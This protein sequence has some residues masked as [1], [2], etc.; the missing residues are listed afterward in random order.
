M[1]HGNFLMF[2]IIPIKSQC[3]SGGGKLGIYYIVSN[4]DCLLEQLWVGKE[5]YFFQHTTV[6]LV[7]PKATLLVSY[8]EKHGINSRNNAV[9]RR[10]GGQ[11]ILPR[12]ICTPP[13]D[14]YH[15]GSP[16]RFEDT[17][18]RQS[19]FGLMT[20]NFSV[21]WGDFLIHVMQR[22]DKFVG[23]SWLGEDRSGMQ[24]KGK[25]RML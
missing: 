11:G 15:S 14:L 7:L 25:G 12:V 21:F 1:I 8:P 5:T 2:G 10:F 23:K 17:G 20:Y 19:L 6:L 4:F 13:R 24:W 9:I 3:I 18:G 22:C 16:M